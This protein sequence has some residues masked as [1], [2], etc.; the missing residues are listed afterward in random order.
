MQD[1][2]FT[3]KPVPA[4]GKDMFEGQVGTVKLIGPPDNKQGI[5]LFFDVFIDID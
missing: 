3:M 4:R 2:H 5:D 1:F